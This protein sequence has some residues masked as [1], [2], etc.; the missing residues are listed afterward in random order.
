MPSHHYAINAQKWSW[1]ESYEIFFFRLILNKVNFLYY[2][3]AV[4]AAVLEH[5]ATESAFESSN[6]KVQNTFYWPI[7]FR[8]VVSYN[9]L[10]QCQ[11]V[12]IGK[13]GRSGAFDKTPH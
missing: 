9:V 12:Y 6:L 1:S 5:S 8:T 3:Q 13:I 10:C 2:R 7:L 11:S 4:V